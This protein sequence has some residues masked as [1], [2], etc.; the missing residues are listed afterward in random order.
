MMI[1]NFLTGEQRHCV[2]KA[3]IKVCIKTKSTVVSFSLK[4]QVTKH[5]NRK[6]GFSAEFRR[7][8]N[9]QWASVLPITS[10]IM[11]IL[12]WQN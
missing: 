12:F 9:D 11:N 7:K 3:G 4:G 1:R 10:F 5:T 2:S 8:K 6:M